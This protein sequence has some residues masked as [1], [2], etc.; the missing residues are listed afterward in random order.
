MVVLPLKRA[1]K[2][3][4]QCSFFINHITHW[5]VPI[6]DSLFG[7]ARAAHY[8][9]VG[10][11]VNEGMRTSL[12]ADTPMTDPS[13]LELMKAATTRIA[14]D[15]RCLGEEERITVEAALKSVTIDAAYHIKMEQKLGSISPGKHAD[16]VMLDANPLETPAKKLTDINVLATYLAGEAVWKS[17]G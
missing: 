16:F 6:E 3:G 9:P 17:G 14:G 12:H 13:A 8:M 1:K 11:A 15:G 10:S 4:V 5:G 7:K 2:L